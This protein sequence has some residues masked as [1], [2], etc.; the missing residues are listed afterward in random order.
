MRQLCVH[1]ASDA[2]SDPEHRDI[3]TTVLA[4]QR[5]AAYSTRVTG[6]HSLAKMSKMAHMFMPEYV[7]AHN[8]PA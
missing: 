4:S 8:R 3:S 5:G 1:L 6:L 2:N 7:G